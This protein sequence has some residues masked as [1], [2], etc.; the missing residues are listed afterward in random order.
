MP[1]SPSSA[2]WGAQRFGRLFRLLFLSSRLKL[3]L[4]LQS[5]ILYLVFHLESLPTAHPS[6][7]SR[8]RP[9]T[10]PTT[11]IQ[12]RLPLCPQFAQASSVPIRR[13]W[14]QSEKLSVSLVSHCYIALSPCPLQPQIVP[15][16]LPMICKEIVGTRQR[17]QHQPQYPIALRAWVP[18][19]REDWQTC[20]QAL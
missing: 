14:A 6:L 9:S 12:W 7:C 10:I 8:L 18:R 20:S 19:F 3:L 2:S 4:P 13:A 11:I 17:P 1:C 5:S 16:L 15:R